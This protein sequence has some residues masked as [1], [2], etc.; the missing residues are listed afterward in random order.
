MNDLKEPEEK[1]DKNPARI[2]SDESDE[3]SQLD[4]S[5]AESEDLETSLEDELGSNVINIFMSVHDNIFEKANISAFT[6]GGQF[7]ETLAA[8]TTRTKK[9]GKEKQKISFSDLE[10][11]KSFYL[12]FSSLSVEAQTFAISVYFFAGNTVEY[13]LNVSQEL[14]H[15]FQ[16]EENKYSEGD[17]SLSLLGKYTTLNDLL[18]VTFSKQVSLQIHS[19]WGEED[20]RTVAF[21]PVGMRTTFNKFLSSSPYFTQLKVDL[22]RWL[23]DLM[24]VSTESHLNKG[25]SIKGL[26][27][28]QI[29]SGIGSLS[30]SRIDIQTKRLIQKWAASKD[31]KNRL[32]VGWII[33]G[34]LSNST[35][36]TTKNVFHFIE[37]WKKSEN[38]YLNWSAV[39]SASRIAALA[40]SDD[41]EKLEFA[42]NIAKYSLFESP[43]IVRGTAKTAVRF[44]YKYSLFHAMTTL[45]ELTSWL[46]ADPETRPNIVAEIALPLLRETIST[47]KQESDL[48]REEQSIWEFKDLDNKR[49]V[50]TWSILLK[51]CLQHRKGSFVDNSLDELIETINEVDKRGSEI[52]KTILGS[53]L[54][55]L[56]NEPAIG[57]EISYLLASPSIE[58]SE[59]GKSVI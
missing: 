45:T 15:F 47:I 55:N 49:L 19:S 26:A 36:S 2:S 4:E 56:K 7:V 33:L 20:I 17:E 3:N 35:D 52:A 40:S 32:S 37:D 43:A 50:D 21:S 10:N 9:Q 44:I 22:S 30:S 14:K 29:A 51:Q 31:Y 59:V 25:S 27:Y 48:Q 58:N 53:I 38:T 24:S 42:L 57:K 54:S 16:E 12:W 6:K 23:K 46:Q 41:R 18:T 8:S 11:E 28:S 13:I 34:I 39:T 5:N 1:Q